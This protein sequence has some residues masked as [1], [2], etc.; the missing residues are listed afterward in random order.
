M[1]LYMDLTIVFA[2]LNTVLLAGLLFLYSRIFR[3]SR[4]LY[5][6]GL[7]IFAL[8]LLLQNA[9]TVFAY[10][11]MAPLFAEGVLPYLLSIAILEFASVSTVF[12]ITLG[13]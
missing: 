10:L 11:T 1:V 7:I 6:A 8:A 4:A 12:G 9:M 2:G 5:T 3:K 13:T